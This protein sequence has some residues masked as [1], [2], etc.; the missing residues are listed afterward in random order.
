MEMCEV[1]VLH[2]PQF[3]AGN[4]KIRS[5]TWSPEVHKMCP[6]GTAHRFPQRPPRWVGQ[7]Q[8]GEAWGEHPTHITALSKAGPGPLTT[9]EVPFVSFF[10]NS[11]SCAHLTVV[12]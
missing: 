1:N 8:R 11:P 3:P 7:A 6:Q 4:F 12:P 9:A 2:E 5:W 10:K